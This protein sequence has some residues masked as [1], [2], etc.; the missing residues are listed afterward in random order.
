ML[1]GANSSN[2]EA[3]DDQDNGE[4]FEAK[5]ANLCNKNVQNWSGND[6][7]NEFGDFSEN[8]TGS[9]T[10]RNPRDASASNDG[11]KRLE[12]DDRDRRMIRCK[13]QTPEEAESHSELL[14][15]PTL[16]MVSSIFPLSIIHYIKII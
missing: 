10:N 4:K 5:Y 8:V 13:C 3:A 1:A 15:K 12:S 7:L 2:R 9:L 6:Q 14:S 16:A 11:D